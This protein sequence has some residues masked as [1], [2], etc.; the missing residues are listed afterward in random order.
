MG[1]WGT[2]YH[3][4]VH[5]IG[6]HVNNMSRLQEQISTGSRVIRASDS[7]ADSYRIMSLRETVNN[8]G[9]YFD[10][11]GEVEISMQEAANSI[12]HLSQISTRVGV[13]VTQSA[14]GTYMAD[15]REAIATEIDELL[16]QSVSLANIRVLDRY[17]FG[18]ADSTHPPYEV[19]KVN[20]KITRVEYTGSY[21]ERPIPVGPG[22]RYSGQIVGDRIFRNN[23]RQEAEF[24]GDTG[25]V[26]GSGTSTARGDFWMDFRRT[27]T[28]YSDANITAAANAADDTILG[29]HTITISA[30][31]TKAQLDG[32]PIV[33]YVAGN[34]VSLPSDDGTVVNVNLAAALGDGAYTVTGE[35]EVD[36]DGTKTTLDQDA[37]ASQNVAVKTPDGRFVYVD[38]RN[39]KAEGLEAVRVPGTYD[40]FNTLIGIRDLLLNEHE[41]ST[42]DQLANLRRMLNSVDEI[43]SGFRQ[44]ATIIG[45]RLGAIDSLRDTLDNLSFHADAEADSIEQADIVEVAAELARTQ[46]LYQMSLQATSKVVSMTLLD[47]IR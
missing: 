36:I 21:L 16:E 45:G 25:V 28:G 33:D 7:P 39:I 19:T 6:L 11:L 2:I 18:G 46:T 9:N 26:P 14:N 27:G 34:D 29:N 38:P 30:G 13:L 42:D 40:L 41:L 22:V 44:R 47:Y 15:N 20:G 31:G 4:A 1:S 10:N 43:S 37:F 24:Y 17:I 23:T 8:F 32:G 5:G 12:E 35:M 3:N